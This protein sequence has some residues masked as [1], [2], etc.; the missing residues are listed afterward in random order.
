MAFFDFLKGKPK[1]D[2]IKYPLDT[3]KSRPVSKT[4]ISTETPT[5][6]TSQTSS[7]D[8]E[9][10]KAKDRVLREGDEAID[11]AWEDLE[12]DKASAQA[13][14]NARMGYNTKK[15][16]RDSRSFFGRLLEEESFEESTSKPGG[17]Y[18]EFLEDIKSCSTMEEVY[19]TID[20]WTRSLMAKHRWTRDQAESV[21]MEQLH[22][23][24]LVGRF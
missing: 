15:T 19:R 12:R 21:L 16:G 22:K 10:L 18:R 9:A 8:L 14:R 6:Y 17:Q 1:E 24:G 4:V 23:S 13:W 11:R 7:S 3:V 2:P 20:H 5:K